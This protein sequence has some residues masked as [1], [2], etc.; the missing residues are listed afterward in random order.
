MDEP[1][2][3]NLD[4]MTAHD[5]ANSMARAVEQLQPYVKIEIDDEK[6]T[7]SKERIRIASDDD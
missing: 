2:I 4:G 3:I 6:V 1:I 7:I 5:V